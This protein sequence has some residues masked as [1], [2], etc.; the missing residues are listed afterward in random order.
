MGLSFA[1]NATARRR[2]RSPPPRSGCV[3]SLR[4]AQPTRTS[5]TLAAHPARCHRATTS[6]ADPTTRM[7]SLHPCLRRQAWV[8]CQRVCV[9]FGLLGCRSLPSFPSSGPSRM[10]PSVNRGT[11]I[12]DLDQPEFG[13]ISTC[14][15]QESCP[16]DRIPVTLNGATTARRSQVAQRPTHRRSRRSCGGWP[17]S[18]PRPAH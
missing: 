13:T 12:A 9:D 14:H 10:T 15:R 18:Q 1:R 6:D 16:D 5:S 17:A 3:S 7:A 4:G 11:G 2:I 8:E